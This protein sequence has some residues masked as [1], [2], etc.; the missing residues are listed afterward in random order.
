MCGLVGSRNLETLEKLY[1]DNKRSGR[2]SVAYSVSIYF[3]D[4]NSLQVIRRKLGEYER[5][6]TLNWSYPNEYY[7]LH[8]LAPTTGQINIHPAESNNHSLWHNGIIKAQQVKK[9]QQQTAVDSTWDTQLLLANYLT[10]DIDNIDGSFACFLKTD[11]NGLHFFRNANAQLY[12][13]EQGDVST[14]PFEGSEPVKVGQAMK[15]EYDSIIPSFQFSSYKPHFF[16]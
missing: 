5:P 8:S 12:Y 9:L 10:Y 13:N 4:D 15:V 16:I 14:E 7:I 3:F 2:G 11:H 6:L 1:E